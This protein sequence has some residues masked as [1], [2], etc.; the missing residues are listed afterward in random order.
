M[1]CQTEVG[2]SIEDVEQELY[3]AGEVCVLEE[4]NDTDQLQG[5]VQT[6]DVLDAERHE[7]HETKWDEQSEQQSVIGV[8]T[9]LSQTLKV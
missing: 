8:F 2:S 7:Q 9:A 5:V 3:V 4:I 6:P 1:L